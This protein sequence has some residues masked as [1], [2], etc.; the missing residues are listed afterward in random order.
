MAWS[1]DPDRLRTDAANIA[2]IEAQIAQVPPDQRSFYQ[3]A[4][5]GIMIPP[6]YRLE[7][8]GRLRYVAVDNSQH[9]YNNPKIMIPAVLA[10]GYGVGSLLSAANEI[11]TLA[12]TPI[13]NGMGYGPASL[14]G[15][16]SIPSTAASTTIPTIASRALTDGMGYGPASLAGTGAIPSALSPNLSPTVSPSAPNVN[17][18]NTN[19]GGL[20]WQELLKLFAPLA[21]ALTANKLT[22]PDPSKYSAEMPPELKELLGLQLNQIKQAQPNY[23]LMLRMARGLQP[24]WAVNDTTPLPIRTAEPRY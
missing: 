20:P 1:D 9:W 17:A 10:G 6:G 15:T 4:Q 5:R 22:Q 21:G 16:S 24:S 23:E 19:G 2:A 14:A 12:S 11:P 13:G 18:P 8:N 3:L 7:P